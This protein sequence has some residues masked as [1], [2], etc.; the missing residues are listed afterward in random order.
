MPILQKIFTSWIMSRFYFKHFYFE[1]SLCTDQALTNFI[2]NAI[3]KRDAFDCVP[4]SVHP[5]NRGANV[6][7]LNWKRAMS[8][9]LTEICFL[10]SYVIFELRIP[11]GL[12]SSLSWNFVQT[13]KYC[14][15]SQPVK[16]AVRYPVTH[17]YI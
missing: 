4:Y 2:I 12:P 9:S 1:C 17:I 11:S 7:V 16:V 6:V 5:T 15:P 14:S 13:N 8:L 3:I 10:F